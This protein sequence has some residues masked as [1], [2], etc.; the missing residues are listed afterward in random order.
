MVLWLGEAAG[1]PPATIM[2]AKRA[3]LSVGPHLPALCAA[4][5]K[6]VPWAMISAHLDGRRNPTC[7]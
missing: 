1:I 7:K 3:V 2:K 6:I 4:I 5:R